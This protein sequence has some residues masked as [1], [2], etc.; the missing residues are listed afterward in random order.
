MHE[1]QRM[2]GG[3]LEAVPGF[4]SIEHGGEVH[5]CVALCNE[6]GKLDYS[7]YPGHDKRRQPLPFNEFATGLWAAAVNGNPLS[8][9]P[10]ALAGTVVILFGDE[11][12]M[13][14]L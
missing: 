14:A 7:T 4:S 2:V 11:E 6:E 10:D 12:F 9:M 1:L 13:G 5:R 8:V 3:W